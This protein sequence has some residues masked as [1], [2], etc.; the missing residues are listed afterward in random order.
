[1]EHE[2]GLDVNNPRD[3]ID[4]YLIEMKQQ[5]ASEQHIFTGWY[6]FCISRI[7]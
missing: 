3:F 1:L 5:Q 2:Q 6:A 7:N 4:N